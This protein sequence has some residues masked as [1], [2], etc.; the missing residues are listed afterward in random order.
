M[1]P[2]VEGKKGCHR[3]LESQPKDLAEAPA[4]SLSL[5]EPPPP[6]VALDD[7]QVLTL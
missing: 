4:L 6:Q 2:D 1:T 5:S 7:P 3:L